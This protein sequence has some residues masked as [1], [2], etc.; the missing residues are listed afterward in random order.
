M[1]EVRSMVTVTRSPELEEWA[2]E[3]RRRFE[4]A[5]QPWFEQA[6]A[7]GEVNSFGTAP[8]EQSRG[9]EAVLAI[10]TISMRKAKPQS[11]ASPR[12]VRKM[13]SLIY[14][15]LTALVAVRSTAGGILRRPTRTV[16]W[17]QQRFGG[18]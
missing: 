5:D 8:D 10:W 16:T 18:T 6:T 14:W 17:K 12:A 4:S 1:E 13:K 9:R 11:P 7:Y 2:R 15:V 3:A